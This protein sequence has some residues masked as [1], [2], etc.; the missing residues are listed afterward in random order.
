MTPD[1]L[2]RATG[3]TAANASRF[4]DPIARAFDTWHIDTATRQAAFIAQCAHE[5]MLFSRTV[6]NMNYSAERAYIVFRKYFAGLE[7]AR[8]F[9]GNPRGLA[10]RVY[11]GRMG[12]VQPDDGW[13]F[14]GQGLIHL[15]GRENVTRYANATQRHEVIDRPHLLQQPLLAADSAGWFWHEN[16]CNALADRAAWELLTK[17]INGGLNGYSERLALTK[18]A[19]LALGAVRAPSA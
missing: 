4:A 7:D 19:L 14:R 11:G 1:L 16:G 18:K 13:N 8:Q 12:N 15:T 9:V 17:R 6:E 3:C 5:S 2:R 10:N